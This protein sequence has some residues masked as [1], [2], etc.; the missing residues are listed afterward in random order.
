MTNTKNRYAL[1][2]GAT[3]RIGKELP[4]LFAEN[5]Y[6]LIIVSISIS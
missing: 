2:T 1:I 5:E 4:N 6:N 3:S